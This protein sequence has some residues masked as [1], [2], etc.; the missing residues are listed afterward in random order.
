MNAPTD[1]QTTGRLPAQ[2][3]QQHDALDVTLHDDELLDE[4]ELTAML[5]VA[6]NDAADTDV[7]APLP[8][9]EID[10]LLGLTG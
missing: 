4:T 1:P 3:L 2:R 10:R 5:M 8:Q 7:D 6:V 9:D